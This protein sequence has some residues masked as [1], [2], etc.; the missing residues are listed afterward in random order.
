MQ[1]EPL[2]VMCFGCYCLPGEMQPKAKLPPHKPANAFEQ[3]CAHHPDVDMH[4]TAVLQAVVRMSIWLG[5]WVGVGHEHYETYFPV[6]ECE[7][8]KTIKV[9]GTPSSYRFAYPIL[10][11]AL[12]QFIDIGWIVTGT[13]TTDEVVYIPT[14]KLMHD[15]RDAQVAWEK[16]HA[17]T[18]RP[19][20]EVAP[21]P[22]PP[23]SPV[24]VT[25]EPPAPK[26]SPKK[27]E[28]PRSVAPRQLAPG[29]F[30]HPLEEL[31]MSLP[32]TPT[33]PFVAATLANGEHL[34]PVE[35][36]VLHQLVQTSHEHGVWCQVSIATL[37]DILNDEVK[38]LTS[39]TSGPFNPPLLH[40][41]RAIG[42]LKAANR[43]QTGH[44]T[45]YE[46][47]DEEKVQTD[48]EYEVVAVDYGLDIYTPE[49]EL[50]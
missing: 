44:I 28:A 50:E 13:G 22:I 47:V 23:S 3:L 11:D 24:I 5:E 9:F 14:T 15:L 19:Q 49:P 12:K 40:V 16:K 18:L 45:V 29:V 36:L 26:R 32:I 10:Q 4:G 31:P 34:K 2:E 33:D 41:M 37:V 30:A 42:T 39:D 46:V 7:D 8:R 17:N 48:R 35:R 38:R 21:P 20:L 27:K 6:T 43:V 1:Q 25:D